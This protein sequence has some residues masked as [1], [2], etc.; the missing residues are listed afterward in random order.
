MGVKSISIFFIIL[1]H[2]LLTDAANA[3]PQKWLKDNCPT[4]DQLASFLNDH[5]NSKKFGAVVQIAEKMYTVLNVEDVK[6]AKPL[7]YPETSWAAPQIKPLKSNARLLACYTFGSGIALL[8]NKIVGG[9]P[10]EKQSSDPKL[11]YDE[12]LNIFSYDS[13]SSSGSDSDTDMSQE[14]YWTTSKPAKK[15]EEK[16]NPPATSAEL[17]HEQIRK[18]V[19]IAQKMALRF[20]KDISDTAEKEHLNRKELLKRVVAFLE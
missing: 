13:A 4:K 15:N 1:C 18:N 14:H 6:D 17:A 9:N 19:Q 3:T 12:K 16:Q 20:S 2:T 8:P 7:V 5:K 10:F 11:V